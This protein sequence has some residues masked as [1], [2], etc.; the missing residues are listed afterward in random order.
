MSG[1]SADTIVRTPDSLRTTRI[2]WA[3]ILATMALVQTNLP[4]LVDVPPNP[5]IQSEP[6][7]WPVELSVLVFSPI[8]GY[9]LVWGWQHMGI[10]LGTIEVEHR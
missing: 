3:V 7:V 9:A 10:R 1:E 5:L 6:Y 2:K 8:F 4:K